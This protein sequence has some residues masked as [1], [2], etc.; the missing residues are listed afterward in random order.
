MQGAV[1][2]QGVELPQQTGT[3]GR[4]SRGTAGTGCCSRTA[5]PGTPL[6][7]FDRC[8]D[9]AQVRSMGKT[10]SDCEK[11]NFDL[12]TWPAALLE[13]V[14]P[15]QSRGTLALLPRKDSWVLPHGGV[16]RPQAP[17]VGNQGQGQAPHR[18]RGWG[19]HS[20]GWGSSGSLL[21]C[22]QGPWGWSWGRC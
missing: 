13:V 16:G 8:R 5:L 11:L 12:R 4:R 18:N 6:L 1:G 21:L 10:G 22:S 15:A 7:S 9:P 19:R 3:G 20:C 17:L 14:V 2:V